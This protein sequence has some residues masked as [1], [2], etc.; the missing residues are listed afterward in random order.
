LRGKG[1]TG[2]PC[3]GGPSGGNF[4]GSRDT[5]GLKKRGPIAKGDK[6]SV[7]EALMGGKAAC[8]TYLETLLPAEKRLGLSSELVCRKKGGRAV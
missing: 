3:S 1:G 2:T 6:S 8:L 5:A 7:V 4:R